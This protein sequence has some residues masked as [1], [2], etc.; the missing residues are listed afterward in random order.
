MDSMDDGNEYAKEPY[1]F[2]TNISRPIYVMKYQFDE[3][4]D[5]NNWD[6]SRVTSLESC[7]SNFIAVRKLSINKW[8]IINV[9]NLSECF[10]CCKELRSLDLSSWDVYN[11]KDFSKCFI[12]CESLKILN[13]SNWVVNKDCDTYNMFSN[14]DNLELIKCTQQT[15]NVIRRVLPD[16]IKWV[17]I[18]GYTRKVK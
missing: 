11:V 5:L 12:G 9:T 14:C 8:D 6:I 4:I 13:I 16:S 15:F 17:Y 1:Y 10:E 18:D 2:M 3:Y 7:F